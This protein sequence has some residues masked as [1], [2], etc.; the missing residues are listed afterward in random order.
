MD[1]ITNNSNL[2]LF[3]YTIEE[4]LRFTSQLQ[5]NTNISLIKQYDE[6][7]YIAIQTRL[8]LLRKYTSKAK[9]NNVYFENLISEATDKFPNAKKK[10]EQLNEDFNNIMQ[11]QIEHILSDGTKLN[12]YETI[13]FSM[14]G[15]YLHADADKIKQINKTHESIRFACTRKYVSDIEKVILQLY[16]TLKELGVTANDLIDNNNQAPVLYLGNS[17]S[18][19]QN[20]QKSSYWSNLY[21]H[22][23]SDNE[24]KNLINESS[25]EDFLIFL[26]CVAFLNELKKSPIP[27]KNLKKLV[28]PTTVKN[29]DD[30]SEAQALY[31]SIKNPGL[32]NTVRYSEDKTLAYIRILPNVEEAFVVNTPHVIADLYEISL[33]KDF[34]GQWRVFSIGGHLES[35]YEK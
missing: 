3:V 23:A 31:Y 7:E 19:K 16:E 20:I 18:E 26:T 25:T 1:N 32:S 22:D 11:Q 14:Y 24:V 13:E 15:L 28:Y 17:N 34:K 29:W 10:F 30:F 35:I 9:K 33:A 2:E 8:M 21:G 27:I 12:I 5:I 4:Y 6:A